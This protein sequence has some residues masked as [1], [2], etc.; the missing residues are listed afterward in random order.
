[1]PKYTRAEVRDAIGDS[2]STAMVGAGLPLVSFVNYSKGDFGQLSPVGVIS[3]IGAG[4]MSM[5]PQGN[6]HTYTYAVSFLT[7][8]RDP[9]NTNYTEENAEDALDAAANGFL[10]WVD[11]NRKGTKWQS[12]R[13]EGSSEV[14]PVS[15][16]GGDA[17]WMETFT[18]A[19]EVF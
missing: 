17:F 2:I 3:S 7:L 9:E 13:L 1:M 19:V 6:R 10:S 4:A 16:A 12:L 15:N 8:R 5:T 14:I 18:I 11:S